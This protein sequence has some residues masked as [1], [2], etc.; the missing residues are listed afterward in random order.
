MK[1]ILNEDI[2][3]G[4]VIVYHRTGKKGNPLK[5]I[6]ADGYRVGGGDK[7]GV[8]VYTTYNLESQLKDNMKRLYGSII[9]ESKVLSMKD[10]LIF[11]Y[12]IAK[13]IYGNKNYTLDKQ[14]QLILGKDLYKYKDDNDLKDLISQL[15]NIEYTSE[16]SD[17]F[18]KKYPEIISNLRGLVFTGRTDGNVLV[19][20]DRKNVEPIRYTIDEG[21]TWKNLINRDVY[22]RLKGYNTDKYLEYEHIL[23]KLDTNKELNDEE[24]N[25]LLNNKILI[26]NL[27]SD[28]I[29]ILLEKILL[30]ERDVIIN[31]LL[32]NK[33]LISRL[34]TNGINNILLKKS[35]LKERSNIINIL[36]NNKELV[37]RLD[38]NGINNIIYY[39]SE[40]EKVI[41]ILLNNKELISRLDTKGINN[42][43]YNSSEHEKVINILLNSKELIS[44]LDTKG[45]NTLLEYSLE[46][47]KVMKLLGNKGKEYLSTLD[48]SII[49][50][51]LVHSL[52][53]EKVMNLLGNKG[54][55]YILRK[56]YNTIDELLGYSKNGKQLKQIIKKLRPDL[57]LE[58]KINI[59][60]IIQEEVFKYRE[61]DETKKEKIFDTFKSSYEE[62]LG[63]SWSRDK[64]N[65]RVYNWTF[66]GDDN[67]FIAVRP[68]RS[69]L[70]KLVGVGGNPRSI[71]KGLDEL[72][73]SNL[74]VWGMVSKDIQKLMN[75]KGYITP[76][77]ILLKLLINII[78]KEVF[79]GVDLVVNKDGSAT[80][81]YQDVGKATKYFVANNQYFKELK[82]SSWDIIQ[83]KI[84]SLPMIA[85]NMINIFFKNL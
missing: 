27:N 82:N 31:I 48:D 34:D 24:I 78:P 1:R 40:R 60:K 85:R 38:T 22:K 56:D 53:P 57:V 11:D 12:D 36:L 19:S 16:I 41:N 21:E 42:L 63:S 73:N 84:K 30:K 50:G 9:I 81:D 45:I 74:P 26:S 25:I 66:Y 58:S 51:L 37:S 2:T 44:N 79:G 3:S 43:I 54:K 59:K 49:F 55:E 5:G 17:K 39:S 13:R 52:E 4:S 6:T 77:A 80:L 72:T 20:Y 32:N 23:N 14:L 15:N 10:F 29:N 18:Y 68:Q 8:G 7:Y 35:L 33:E 75:K 61:L 28:E 64:F 76:P 46:P 83:E 69:G 47:E 65:S 70:Q 67:G 62:T 71:L